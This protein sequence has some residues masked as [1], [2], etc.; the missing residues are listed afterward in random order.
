MQPSKKWLGNYEV[1]GG[2]IVVKQNGELACYHIYDRDKFKKYLYLNTRFETPMRSRH[3][4]G[5][6]YQDGDSKFIKLN[7]QIRYMK[8]K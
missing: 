3:K 1:L 2:F 7:L 8:P 4:F 6:I 5:K